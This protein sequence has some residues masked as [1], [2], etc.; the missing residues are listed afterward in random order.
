[1]R[2]PKELSD[3]IFDLILN[4]FPAPEGL[5]VDDIAMSIAALELSTVTLREFLHDKGFDVIVGVG[6]PCPI[7]GDKC[8]DNTTDKQG[9]H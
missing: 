8:P 9:R 6:G 4:Y 7:H 5:T 2:D 1:M 3:K